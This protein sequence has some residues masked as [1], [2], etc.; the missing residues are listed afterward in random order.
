MKKLLS[1]LLMLTLL[2]PACAEGNAPYT[3]VSSLPG[4]YLL[5]CKEGSG[6]V[7]KF[8]YTAH[9]LMTDGGECE[10]SA[11]IYLPYGYDES[12][13]YP[14]L[15]LCHGIGGSESEWGMTSNTCKIACM[16]N[17]MI[18]KGEI[19]P[20][21]IVTPN[22]RA[23][24]TSDVA[25]FYRFGEEIRND[26]LP[27]LEE[28]YAVSKDRNSRA[29]AGLSMG[30]MQTI[31]IGIGE[32]LDLF[33]YFGAFSAA[34]TSNTAAVTAAKLNTSEYDVNFFYSICGTTD[35]VAYAS[36]CMAV[37][38]ITE[39]TDRLTQQNFLRQEQL[40]DHGFYI[41]NLGFF[42]FARIFGGFKG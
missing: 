6:T 29:M 35:K 9:N 21:I 19:R 25:A 11:Y 39:K 24:K 27:Y 41:W 42:N 14:L 33:S 7:T 30:G 4:T 3:P 1:A 23:G 13:E 34:P 18:A 37:D 38:G 26:L 31:N 22:G 17:N 28:H 2:I 16:M 10:K 40:G 20:F 36:A 15:I 12:K 8:T 32:C 5:L